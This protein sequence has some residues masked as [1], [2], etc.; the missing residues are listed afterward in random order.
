MSISYTV[1]FV[2]TKF[3]LKIEK[4]NKIQKNKQS[5]LLNIYHCSHA[6][7]V[8]GGY[9]FMNIIMIFATQILEYLLHE[10]TM[11]FLQ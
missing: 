5:H 9:R 8:D 6:I 2:F 4:K 11:N 3:K 1:T 10:C 7:M